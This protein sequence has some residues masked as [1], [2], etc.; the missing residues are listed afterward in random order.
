MFVDAKK[1]HLNPKCEASVFC[2]LPEEAECPEGFCAKLNYWLYGF[3]P[4]AAARRLAQQWRRNDD[5]AT[6]ATQQPVWKHHDIRVLVHDRTLD[7]HSGL[8]YH[9]EK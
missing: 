5:D 2:E 9:L 8:Y 4:A 3:R 7:R 6:A 1:A